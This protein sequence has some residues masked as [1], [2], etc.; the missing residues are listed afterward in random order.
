MLRKCSV[1][2]AGENGG[3]CVDGV[4]ASCVSWRKNWV[5]REAAEVFRLRGGSAAGSC[6]STICS[7]AHSLPGALL[8]AFCPGLR[9]AIGTRVWIHSPLC[10]GVGAR[11]TV[12]PP[13]P[14]SWLTD[15]QAPEGQGGGGARPAQ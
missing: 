2:S 7:D 6:P 11:L 3:S 1:S 5:G 4:V 12:G 9:G 10:R 8:A 15:P 13:R 14:L